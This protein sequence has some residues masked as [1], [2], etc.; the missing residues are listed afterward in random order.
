[1]DLSAARTATYYIAHP[2]FH[3]LNFILFVLAVITAPLLH[4]GNFCL[5]ACWYAFHVLGKFEASQMKLG[6]V[7]KCF[8]GH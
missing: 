7:D 1:M 6:M 2:I 4:L 5:S 8:M 3:L